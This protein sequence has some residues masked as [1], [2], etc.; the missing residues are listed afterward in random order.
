MRLQDKVVVITGAARGLGQEYARR[1]AEEGASIVVCDRRDIGDTVAVVEKAGG[2]A[3][4]LDTDVTDMKSCEALI[5]AAV[6]KFGR[7]DTLI[8]NAA[9]YGS[10]KVGGF[11]KIDEDEWDATMDVNVKAIWQMCKAVAPV[12]REQNSG[13]IINIS[14]LAATYGMPG[15]LHYTVSKAAVIGVTRGLAREL[16]RNNIR[17]NSV[18]PTS[19]MTDA[20]KEMFGD[21]FDRAVKGVADQQAI[22]RNLHEKDVVGMMLFLASDD[23]E[24]VTGQTLMVDGGTT[25]L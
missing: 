6:D 17:V 7:V 23:S 18:A 11:E 9:L 20:T 25:L 12:M 3:I 19:V 16:G 8:N 24:F 5:G 14:S 1:M 2:K 13:S 10:L 22:S 15:L 4:G 21:R